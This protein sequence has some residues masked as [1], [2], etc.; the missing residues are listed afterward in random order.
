MFDIVIFLFYYVAKRN[1]MTL[2]EGQAILTAITGF[3]T[4][5]DLV[6]WNIFVDTTNN[7]EVTHRFGL[8]QVAKT[9]TNDNDSSAPAYLQ[10]MSESEFVAELNT[11]GSYGY[12]LT[13]ASTPSVAELEAQIATLEEDLAVANGEP[14]VQADNTQQS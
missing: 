3:T 14:N 7:I 13:P 1:Q 6:T 8:W 2:A 9:G 12:S 5:S 4:V 11:L 10:A